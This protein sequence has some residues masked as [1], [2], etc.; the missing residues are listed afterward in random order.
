MQKTLCAAV[1]FSLFMCTI[2][3]QTPQTLSYQ[4]VIR[5]NNDHLLTDSMIGIQI[6]II[7]GSASGTSVYSEFQ[8]TATN[9]NGLISI[10]IGNE[11][12]FDTINWGNG[13]YF[14]KT[15]IDITGGTNFTISGINQ[16]LT[17]PYAL[18]AHTAENIS[19]MI[20]ETDPTWFGLAD[21]S[22][23]IG[24]AGSVGIGTMNPSALLHTYGTGTGGGNVLFEGVY[25]SSNPGNPP[26]QGAGTRMMWYPDRAAFRVGYVNGMQWDIYNIG[27]YSFA[28]GTNTTANGNGSIAM[29]QNTTA[30]GSGSIAM[31]GATTAS[32][33]FSAALGFWNVASGCF[34]TAL[35]YY[36]NAKSGYETVIGRYNTNYSPLDVFG[37]NVAD[38]LFVVGKGTSSSDRSDALV[39]LKNG[40]IGVGT[41]SPEAKFTV[42]DGGIRLNNTTD[43]MNWEINYDSAN[44]YFYIDENGTERWLIIQNTSGYVGL[45]TT[46]PAFQLHLSQN[47]AAKPTSNVWTVASDARLKTNISDYKG[48]LNEI[49]KIHPVWFTYTGE[50]G[51]P[52]ETGVG[53]IAQDLQTIAPYMVNQWTY[54]TPDG[55][56]KNYLGVDNGAMTYMLI[57]AVKEQ[58]NIIQSLEN[59]IDILKKQYENLLQRIEEI[60]N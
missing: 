56:E 28:A 46:T 6:S 45:G 14:L 24:R 32:G 19:G 33:Q 4:A 37:W 52:Q 7:Q 35:G 25:K 21:T 38:R 10:E 5:D 48:G 50:A 41:S 42:T 57:N 20:S 12:G 39:I 44:D 58:Q 53:V 1:F 55:V 11:T 26:M 8:N 54:N 22:G 31:G 3:A 47:S 27:A 51:L 9:V 23:A 18:Y 59:E 29:G 49:L 30:S 2:F 17:V 16:M 34:S 15:E 60:D 13:P 36:T 40:F 43:T